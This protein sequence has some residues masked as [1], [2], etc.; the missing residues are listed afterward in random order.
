MDGCS[1][2]KVENHWFSSTVSNAEQ[3]QEQSFR[4][5]PRTTPERKGSHLARKF[6]CG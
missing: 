6:A 5:V 1:A 2:N 3:T 4:T